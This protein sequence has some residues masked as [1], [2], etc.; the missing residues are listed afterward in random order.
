[1]KGIM[2]SEKQNSKSYTRYGS[3]HV[4][5]SQRHKYSGRDSMSSHRGFRMVAGEPREG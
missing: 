1:M 3:I 5:F 2:L 4:T